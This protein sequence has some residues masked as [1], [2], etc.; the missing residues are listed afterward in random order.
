[1]IENSGAEGSN[2][3]L[4]ETVTIVDYDLDGFLDLFVTNGFVYSIILII[5]CLILYLPL[6]WGSSLFS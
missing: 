3:G 2:N 5:I 4:G 1:L 6:V